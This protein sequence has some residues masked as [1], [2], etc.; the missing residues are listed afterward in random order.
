ME[1]IRDLLKEYIKRHCFK[2]CK[3]AQKAGLNSAKL[4]AILTKRRKIDANELFALCAAME[5]TPNE[6]K[7]S[8]EATK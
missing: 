5:T 7:G 6:L 2:H 1:D 8:P 4:S 3:V